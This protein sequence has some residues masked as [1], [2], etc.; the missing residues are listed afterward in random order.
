MSC[1]TD[2]LAPFPL[3]CQTFQVER[4]PHTDSVILLSTQ[5][6]AIPNLN[7]GGNCSNMIPFLSK[8]SHWVHIGRN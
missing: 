2:H 1:L 5:S 3:L 7:L 8:E 4:L 6:L